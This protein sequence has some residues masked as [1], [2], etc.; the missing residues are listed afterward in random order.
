[1]TSLETIKQIL[2]IEEDERQHS[3]Q[4]K[5]ERLVLLKRIDWIQVTHKLPSLQKRVYARRGRSIFVA[6]RDYIWEEDLGW[7]IKSGSS[8]R[9]IVEGVDSWYPMEK[10]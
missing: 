1:M 6:W 7:L 2:S 5:R 3:I 10:E 4:V 9:V 8:D